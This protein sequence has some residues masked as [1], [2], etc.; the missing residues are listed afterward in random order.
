MI[1]KL[2]EYCFKINIIIIEKRNGKWEPL[3]P[4]CPTPYFWDYDESLPT[5]YV[6]KKKKYDYCLADNLSSTISQEIIEKKINRTVRSQKVYNYIKQYVDFNGKCRRVLTKENIWVTVASRP[7]ECPVVDI[8][9]EYH[10]NIR[11]ITNDPRYFGTQRH[12]VRIQ[13]TVEEDD[14]NSDVELYQYI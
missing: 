13:K 3:I 2:Y 14:N 12:I 4:N 1:Y 11:N 8:E 5:Y 9:P 7:L 6:I 10:I